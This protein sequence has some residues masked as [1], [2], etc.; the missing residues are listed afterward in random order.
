VRQADFF[1]VDWSETLDSLPEPLLIIGNPPWA[2]NSEL[3]TIGSSN[4][5]VKSN[6]QNHKGIEAITGKAN[7]DISEWMLTRCLE[8]M[9]GR[10]AVLAMLCKAAVAR[11]VLFQCWKTGRDPGRADMYLIDSHKVF[12]AAVTGCLLVVDSSVASR[13]VSCRVYCS[14]DTKEQSAACGYLDDTLIAN[15]GGC[16]T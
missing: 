6:F 3:G 16:R 4:L 11:R 9:R 15:L 12:G 10:R 1:G 5:P 8:W 7:F 14:L 2:T 13:N